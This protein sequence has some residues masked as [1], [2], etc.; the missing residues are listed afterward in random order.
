MIKQ[1][2]IDNQLYLDFLNISPEA[3]PVKD[4]YLDSREFCKLV[5]KQFRALVRKY[6]PDF[7]GSDEEFKFLQNAKA[8]L[9]DKHSESTFALGVNE[10]D[11]ADF[12]KESLAA[13]LGNQLFELISG[14]ADEL[15]IKP[16]FR[17]S[18][19][20]DS[21]EWIFHQ[22][23]LDTQLSIN[24]QTLTRELEELSHDL[25]Q[26][27]S[28]SVLVCVFIPSTKMV[29]N[30]IAYNDTKQ[31]TFDDKILLESSRGSE[32]KSYFSS[33]DNIKRDLESIKNG[34]FVSKN[35]NVLKIKSS[36][37]A[38]EKD[39]KI[40]EYLQNIKL[41]N[42]QYDESAADFLETL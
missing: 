11:L 10:N 30:K 28:L 17:P 21:Y 4:E 15:N 41:F 2:I 1:F 16:L 26:N 37:S 9:L 23:D 35:N 32:L 5:E 19:Q 25:Y 38:I 34:D 6:H 24:I 20:N 36:K 22:N 8:S 29:V 3:I 27:D 42:T 14:W 40:I 31:I 39:K 13:K 18:G 33:V 7:G 12:D